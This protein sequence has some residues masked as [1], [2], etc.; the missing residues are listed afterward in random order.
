MSKLSL[1]NGDYFLETYHIF[2]NFKTLVNFEFGVKQRSFRQSKFFW[3]TAA[4]NHRWYQF[5]LRRNDRGHGSAVSIP[6]SIVGKRQCRVL[7]SGYINFDATGI[8]MT[9]LFG[10]MQQML[11][12]PTRS[13]QAWVQGAKQGQFHQF[14]RSNWYKIDIEAVWKKNHC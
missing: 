8:D 6:R 11:T 9:G 3:M 14:P 1:F 13:I 10:I 2:G 5:R 12:L 4:L 7:I